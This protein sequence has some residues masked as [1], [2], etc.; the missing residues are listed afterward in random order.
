MPTNAQFASTKETFESDTSLRA[1]VIRSLIKIQASSVIWQRTGR[2]SKSP[3]IIV[4]CV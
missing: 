1:K 4:E 3:V 2:M